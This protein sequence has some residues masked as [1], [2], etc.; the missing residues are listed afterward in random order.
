[1]KP[2]DGVKEC[3]CHGCRHVGV[4][5]RDEVRVLGESV[6]HR[7]HHRFAVDAWECLDEIHCDVG[8]YR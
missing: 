7:E 4:V 1:V 8:P 5:E 6:D 2:D 3:L